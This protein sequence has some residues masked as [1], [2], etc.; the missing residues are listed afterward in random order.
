MISVL[1]ISKNIR[2][3]NTTSKH[4]CITTRSSS[5]AIYFS[6]WS[7]CFPKVGN[8]LLQIDYGGLVYKTSGFI[9]EIVILV[10]FYFIQL[11]RVHQGIMSGLMA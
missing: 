9:I 3:S 11:I 2:A 4:C 6:K 8:Q 7:R 1:L 10:M 5:N